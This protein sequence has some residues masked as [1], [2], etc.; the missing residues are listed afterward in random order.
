MKIAHIAFAMTWGGG[1]KQMTDLIAGLHQ[2]SIENYL[3]C[4]EGSQLSL[5]SDKQTR[6]KLLRSKKDKKQN[7]RT[8]KKY[9]EQIQP[10][11]I[12]I[13]TGSALKTLIYADRWLKMPKI[14]WVLKING[15]I[16]KK[17]I[18][19]KFKYNY[20][21]IIA[22]HFVTKAALE[23]YKKRVAFRKNYNKLEV[24]YD[25][26]F[27]DKTEPSLLQDFRQK[28]IYLKPEIKII[29]NI[30]N[31]TEAKNLEVFLEMAKFL[32]YQEKRKDLHF[33]Q[34]GRKTKFTK[35]F[36][37]LVTDYGLEQHVT[38]MGFLQDAECFIP[39]FDVMA[40]SSKRE[41]IPLTIMEA[42]K[43]N[44]PVVSTVAGGIPECI[45][46]EQH[47]ML[48]PI[49]DAQALGQNIVKVLDDDVLK[50]HIVNQANEM[51]A[52]RFTVFKMTQ[53]TIAFYKSVL[54]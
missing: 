6:L 47:G 40:I 8:L 31:H 28:L 14:P 53:N 7:A 10:H 12:H 38:F 50:Q 37:Q 48:S 34:I 25:G 9:I 27:L 41:G 2:K 19:S 36:E 23:N 15:M 35:Q 33:I 20:K 11:I 42:F 45:T 44:V 3:V 22:T 1:E 13:H 43:Y 17:S 32:V 39:Q 52:E 5:C 24:I 26:I 49:G 16:R 21:R 18:F 51:L 30:A 4:F 29:G 46:H 54:S